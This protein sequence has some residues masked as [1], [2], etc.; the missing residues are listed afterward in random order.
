M[1][2]TNDTGYLWF[3]NADN[4]EVVVKVLDGCAL[5]QRY[6]VFAGGLTDVEVVMKVIDSQT[7]VAATYL[8]P[9][10]NRLQARPG[11]EHVRRLPPGRQ[12]LR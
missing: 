4:V 11:P 10:G 1:P 3:F 5:N 12:S 6:W 2:L 7:G 8:Q 9:A